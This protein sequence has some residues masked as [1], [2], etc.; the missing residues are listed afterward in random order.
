M[1]RQDSVVIPSEIREKISQTPERY[2]NYEQLGE[3]YYDKN[4]KQSYLCYEHAYE[5]CND[6][7]KRQELRQVLR[8]IASDGGAVPK[9]AIVILTSHGD[10]SFG[11]SPIY[12]NTLTLTNRR[13]FLVVPD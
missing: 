10:G 1:K 12:T 11:F 3:F 13:P 6:E 4:M 2:E 9:T 5:L 8:S 7:N